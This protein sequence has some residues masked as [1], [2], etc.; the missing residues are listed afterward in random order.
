MHRRYSFAHNINS[1]FSRVT[2][3][4]V[5]RSEKYRIRYEYICT[6]TAT[7]AGLDLWPCTQ[8]PNIL[9]NCST[10]WLMAIEIFAEC[11]ERRQTQRNTGCAKG[12]GWL[13]I[14]KLFVNVYFHVVWY[15][16]YYVLLSYRPFTGL[17]FVHSWIP[18]SIPSQY[19]KSQHI[20]LI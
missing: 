15:E 11:R 8:H 2:V 19:T 13:H 5:C 7:R 17:C 16:M 12:A 20:L 9:H 10:I 14:I 6:R 1:R 18:H 3:S 4:F